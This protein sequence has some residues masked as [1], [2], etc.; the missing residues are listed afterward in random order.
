M[1]E[2]LFLRLDGDEPVGPETGAPAE[3]AR[4][5]AVEPKLRA[6]LAPILAWNERLPEAQGGAQ[7]VVERVLPDGA[8]HIG[9][10]L[11]DRP[12]VDG[13]VAHVAAVVGASTAPALVGLRGH[14]DGLTICVRPGA[15]AA[16]LGVPA[17]AL[18]DQA[19]GLDE[20][21]GDDGRELIERV[22]AVRTTA[23]RARI[24][25]EVLAR[26]LARGAAVGVDHGVRKAVGHIAGSGGRVTVRELAATLGVTERRLQQ[27]FHAHVG[28]APRAWR[29]L[30][31]L[32]ACLRALRIVRGA[33]RT[34]DERDDRAARVTSDRREKP[35][36]AWA[37]LASDAGFYDQA[38]LANEV[39]AL[40][41]LSPSE[42]LG[43]TSVE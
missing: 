42:L 10:N 14:I 3:A 28:L 4:E 39:R 26:R 31:R 7:S 40:S 36:L 19:V 30:A 12:I 38:H 1:A 43:A 25:Q 11:G 37:K 24:V 41:G 8:V 27:R 29:R 2:R 34:H 17:G 20:L 5:V 33:S 32:H 18:T 6:Y 9:V 35:R 21:W 15:V 13:T 23:A 22:A 16:V